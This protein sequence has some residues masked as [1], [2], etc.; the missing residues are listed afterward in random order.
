MTTTIAVETGR[1]D[2]SIPR[3][4]A[5]TKASAND[6]INYLAGRFAAEAITLTVCGTGRPKG[7]GKAEK[8]S[9]AKKEHDA[10]LKNLI[11]EKH[12]KRWG[13]FSRS[14]RNASGRY[15][16]LL[17]EKETKAYYRKAKARQGELAAGWNAAMIATAATYPSGT[18]FV[19]RHGNVHG[20]F[21]RRVAPA[22]V[23]AH[24]TW[25]HSKGTHGNME[26][27]SA[28]ALKNVND[29]AAASSARRLTTNIRRAAERYLASR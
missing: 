26:S 18:S 5:A 24:I 25:E 28:M 8:P 14:G 2:A 7:A 9:Q 20:T 21:S 13:H 17:S 29:K 27:I 19:K 23:I 22:S 1:L 10:Y 12:L 11:L 4:I 15:D 3:I 6:V 16:L